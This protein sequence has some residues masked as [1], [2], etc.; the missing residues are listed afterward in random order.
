MTS[1][2]TTSMPRQRLSLLTVK[3]DGSVNIAGLQ[4]YCLAKLSTDSLTERKTDISLRTLTQLFAW[5]LCNTDNLGGKDN[6]K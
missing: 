6:V 3:E 1:M 5:N 4:T 2:Q